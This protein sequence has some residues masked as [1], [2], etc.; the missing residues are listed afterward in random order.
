LKRRT[1]EARKKAKG[2][3]AERGEGNPSRRKGGEAT[4]RREGGRRRKNHRKEWKE[5][6][7]KG[8]GQMRPKGV[9]KKLQGII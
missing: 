4:K 8:G 2:R 7:K 9:R 5:R 6:R 1:E 3:R